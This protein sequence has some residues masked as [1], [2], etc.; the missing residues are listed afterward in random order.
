MPLPRPRGLRRR[1]AVLLI[2]VVAV[3]GVEV[4]LPVSSAA[5]ETVAA[6]ADSG[7]T[8]DPGLRAGECTLLGRTYVAQLGCARDRCVAGAV[9]W[10]KVPGAEACALPGQPQGFGFA[11]TV[12]VRRC[13]ALQRRWVEAVN[14]CAS[15][16]DRSLLAVRDAPQCAPPASVYVILSEVEGRYD[17]CLTTPAAEAL[18]RQAARNGSTLA[19]E[20][21]E[22]QRLAPASQGGVLVVGDSVTWRGG[23][24]L[25]G[26]DPALTVDA[27]P[28]RRPTE[29]KAALRTFQARHGQPGGL[30]VELGTNRA[31][32]YGRRDLAD[33][34][35]TL[36][37]HVS[38]L[39][40]LP[41]VEVAGDPLAASPWSVRVGGWMRSVAAGRADTCAADW[42][43]Y[44]RAHPGLLQDGIHPWHGA[45][46][47]WAAW[48][49]QQWAS[50]RG[51]S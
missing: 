42:P 43:A 7:T 12:D 40:V 17:E 32:D 19:A 14:Y 45:E 38:V 20:L 30:V 41:Y 49:S 22:R 24:E 33:A 13:Q 16:P 6:L 31:P 44:V 23:D 25:A 18:S 8:Y 4:A 36:P 34:L 11:A 3:V 39:L 21:A 2:G 48:V 15:Q 50:C 37:A 28:G 46:G 35:R 9:P 27:E 5:P 1:L 51:R 10:R 47:Q 26:L 29:L